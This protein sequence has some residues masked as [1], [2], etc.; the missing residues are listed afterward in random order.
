[1]RGA[2][3]LLATLA[4]A[5]AAAGPASAAKPERVF[6][7]VFSGETV[8]DPDWS[9][10]CGFDVHRTAKG[11]IRG[12]VYLDNDGTFRRFVAH[13]SFQ[14]TLTSAW[15]SVTTADRG[16]DRVTQNADGTL[17][18]HGTGIHLRIKGQAYAIG[19]WRLVIDPMTG[20]IVSGTYHGN[21]D[22]EAPEIDAYVCSQLAP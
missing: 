6:R 7:D 13:P 22:L 8:R 20:E 5:V 19:L 14:Y 21:F 9:G 10:T 12:T 17:T 11:Q 1:M 4:V 2:V 3:V 16:M 18:I 15:G